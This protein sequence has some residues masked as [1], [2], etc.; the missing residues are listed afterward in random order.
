[1]VLIIVAV[2]CAQLTSAL[3]PLSHLPSAHPHLP[4]GSTHPDKVP[5]DDHHA[6]CLHCLAL[7]L[8][9]VSLWLQSPTPTQPASRI[10]APYA[11]ATASLA[12]H[13]A[14]PRC[15]APPVA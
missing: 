6:P 7:Q 1:M 13:C 3:H 15:R 4:S 14:R 10:A 11:T 8:V 12:H 2:L 5:T 9:D